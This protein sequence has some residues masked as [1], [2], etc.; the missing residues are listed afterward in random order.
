MCKFADTGLI[1]TYIDRARDTVTDEIVALKKVRMENERDGML[2]K[3][4]KIS[5]TGIPISSLREI[6]LLLS[7]KHPNIVQLKEVVV[8]R[9]LDRYSHYHSYQNKG[10]SRKK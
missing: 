10:R 2:N 7:L 5:L 6:T 3:C 9:S 8:G 1:S 4:A